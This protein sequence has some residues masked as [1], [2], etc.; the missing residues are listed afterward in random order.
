MNFIKRMLGLCGLTATLAL[1]SG[2]SD[3]TYFNVSVYLRQ[4]G[5]GTVDGPTLE[6]IT[7][8][9]ISVFSGGK[10]IENSVELTR[11]GGET[12]CKPGFNGDMDIVNDTKVMKV[13]VLD[14]SSARQS[15]EL[16]FV[17]TVRTV[18]DENR[19]VIAQGT[20]SAGVKPGKVLE[21]PLI[22]DSCAKSDCQDIK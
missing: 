9:S 16:D 8:C 4:S 12:I 22:I 11:P 19:P 17:V 5:D 6:K 2:C 14:Y 1:A 3:Y 20:A 18:Q 21:V 15:G 7:S 10:Q 13:G